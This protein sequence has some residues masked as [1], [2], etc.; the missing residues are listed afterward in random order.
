MGGKQHERPQV[1]ACLLC[2]LVVV[3]VLG[4]ACALGYQGRSSVRLGP[5][6]QSPATCNLQ[7]PLASLTSFRDENSA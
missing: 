1:T 7:V 4:R 6:W 3:Q 5:V 2:M